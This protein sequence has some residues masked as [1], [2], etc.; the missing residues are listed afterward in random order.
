MIKLKICSDWI[1]TARGLTTTSGDGF[2]LNVSVERPNLAKSSIGSLY[3]F[4]LDLDRQ[5]PG[6]RPENS[7]KIGQNPDA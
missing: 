7:S 4:V 3:I 2:T 1:R 6:L 5:T